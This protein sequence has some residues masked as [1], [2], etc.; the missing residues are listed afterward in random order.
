MRYGDKALPG[1]LVTRYGSPDQSDRVINPGPVWATAFARVPET[2]PAR[3]D[4]KTSRSIFGKILRAPDF[5]KMFLMPSTTQPRNYKR[6]TLSFAGD[7]CVKTKP[8][9]HK[10]WLL[11]AKISPFHG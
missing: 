1:G 11:S 5:S 2:N 7:V 9:N 6:A 4:R 8:P 10:I 3:R